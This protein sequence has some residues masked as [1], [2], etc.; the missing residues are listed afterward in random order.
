MQSA[1]YNNQYSRFIEFE[2]ENRKVWFNRSSRKSNLRRLEF[3]EFRLFVV[4]W[5]KFII[6]DIVLRAN[7]H[8]MTQSTSQDVMT[9]QLAS[10]LHGQEN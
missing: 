5:R 2:T 9:Y 7:V 8:I 3:H 10:M 6:L 1:C 4:A